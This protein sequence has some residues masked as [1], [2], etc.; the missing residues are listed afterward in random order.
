MG[1]VILCGRW[2]IFGTS[3]GVP[4]VCYAYR[5]SFRIERTFGHLLLGVSDDLE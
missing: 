5:F 3:T 1:A 4:N 2:A